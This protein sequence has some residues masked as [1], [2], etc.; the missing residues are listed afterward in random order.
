MKTPGVKKKSIWASL[1]EAVMMWLL[2]FASFNALVGL[3]NLGQM[4]AF[5]LSVSMTY[6]FGLAIYKKRRSVNVA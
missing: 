2:W 1:I 3:F 5:L 4:A 6:V